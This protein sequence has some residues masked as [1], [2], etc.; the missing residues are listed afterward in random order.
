MFMKVLCSKVRKNG[1]MRKNKSAKTKPKAGS[2]FI[3]AARF[4][5]KRGKDGAEFILFMINV[6]F[7]PLSL[8]MH[9]PAHPCRD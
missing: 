6:Y 9:A 3:N 2:I 8:L 1:K 5:I 4:F 7:L